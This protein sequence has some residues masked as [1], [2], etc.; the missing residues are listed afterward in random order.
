MML[1]PEWLRQLRAAVFQVSLIQQCQFLAEH[2]HGPAVQN[3][4]VLCDEQCMFATSLDQ[5]TS[6]KSTGI[7]VKRFFEILLHQRL[8]HVIAC[9]DHFDHFEIDLT[10]QASDNSDIELTCARYRQPQ[11]VMSLNQVRPCF[12]Q[13][14]WVNLAWEF[15]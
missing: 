5:T 10:V 3:D 8:E 13:G 7:H 4:V 15:I 11:N 6:Q 14:V 12:A 2:W 9:V 1:P